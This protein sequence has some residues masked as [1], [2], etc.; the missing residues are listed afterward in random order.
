M[1]Q[2]TPFYQL[3]WCF[4]WLHLQS[5]HESK[6]GGSVC[7][8][9]GTPRL[10]CLLPELVSICQQQKPT[11]QPDTASFPLW[12]GEGAKTKI[13]TCSLQRQGHQLLNSPRLA[14]CTHCQSVV[15]PN[16]LVSSHFIRSNLYP[17]NVF[18]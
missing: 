4:P 14:V 12:L 5:S 8:T 9:A 3:P 18:L 6:K 7:S 15:S 11:S 17:T 13:K 10:T 2:G 16:L 1:D